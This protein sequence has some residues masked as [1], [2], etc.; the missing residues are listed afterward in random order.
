MGASYEQDF[1]D[2]A[3]DADIVDDVAEMEHCFCS[4]RDCAEEG[5]RVVRTLHEIVPADQ[6]AS[7]KLETYQEARSNLQKSLNALRQVEETV[8]R[9]RSRRPMFVSE[10][11]TPVALRYQALTKECGKNAMR[12]LKRTMVRMRFVINLERKLSESQ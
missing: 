8:E 11:S 9:I 2:S 1:N 6:P 5:V 12:E 10:R 4:I 3:V 7:L